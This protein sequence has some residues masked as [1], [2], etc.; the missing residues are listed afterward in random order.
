MQIEVLSINSPRKPSVLA[1]AKV[2]LVFS[3]GQIIEV[4]DI[5]ILKNNRGELWI[6]LPTYSMQDGRNYR[7]EKTVEMSKG[8][9]RQIETAV[10][11][12][13]ESWDPGQT[14]AQAIGGVR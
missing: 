11:T 1:T 14:S 6:A 12:S 8:L 5:R 7:Y 3:E 2:R 13:Y 4:D 9:H 10:L